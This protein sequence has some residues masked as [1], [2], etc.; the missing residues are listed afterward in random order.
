VH[1]NAIQWRR[2]RRR[3]EAAPLLEA[4][5][6]RSLLVAAVRGD[7]AAVAE[8]VQSHMRLVVKIA[9]RYQRGNLSCQDLV[10]EGVLGMME[11]MRRFD[12]AQETRFSAYASWWIRARIGQ[13]ALTNRRL[14]PVPSTRNA[15]SVVRRLRKLEQLLAQRLGRAASLEEL[16]SA[17]GVGIDDVLEVQAAL[18]GTD[19]SLTP[20]AGHPSV[21][22]VS[23]LES[24]EQAIERLQHQQ[25][26]QRRIRQA[27][28]GLS[29]WELTVVQEQYLEEHGRSLSQL[30]AE[31]GVSRQ[32][33]GQVLSNARQKLKS[34]LE[35]VA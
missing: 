4:D 26:R 35:H 3:C 32:R 24:P 7:A 18:S 14:V 6:E 17:L 28:A 27:L 23:E 31:H 11:A 33:V 10:S 19:V 34:Q 13:Y 12:L 20:T 25:A 15:R 29:P 16:A 5:R 21:E 30:G 8:L 2:L 9:A 1:E 22:P